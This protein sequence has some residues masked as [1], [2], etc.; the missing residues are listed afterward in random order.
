MSD[1][2]IKNGGCI[3]EACRLKMENRSLGSVYYVVA[4]E[5][6]SVGHAYY[7]PNETRLEDI[8][9]NNSDNGYPDYP[10]LKVH[11]VLE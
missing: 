10:Q 1:I 4:T 11:E 2:L 3:L 5:K 7:V 6:M 8:A 9:L